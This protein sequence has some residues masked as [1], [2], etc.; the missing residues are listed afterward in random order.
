MPKENAILTK[1]SKRGIIKIYKYGLREVDIMFEKKLTTKLV[2]EGMHC[3]HCKARVEA[4]IKAV[5]GV[6]SYTVT[7]ENAEAEVV[8]AEGKTTPAAIASAVTAC[9]FEA[10]VK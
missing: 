2:I 7:L 3:N 8:Y 6:K 5:K 1:P 10:S 9:G 4:A